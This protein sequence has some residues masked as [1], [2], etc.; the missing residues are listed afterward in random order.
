MKDCF[1]IP[2][3]V[4]C[5]HRNEV[6][7]RMDLS[8]VSS[9]GVRELSNARPAMNQGDST[10]VIERED[11]FKAVTGVSNITKPD[12]LRI[13]HDLYLAN[14]LY[15]FQAFR[16]FVCTQEGGMH[17]EAGIYKRMD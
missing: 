16:R 17:L 4:V 15:S 3:L 9:R 13:G 8:V 14:I 12:Q 1:I 11:R 2:H 6:P 10:A 5:A 7:Y